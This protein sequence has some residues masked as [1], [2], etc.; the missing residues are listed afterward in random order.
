MR[1]IFFNTIIVLM[2]PFGFTSCSYLV[3]TAQPNPFKES[4]FLMGE[5]R[6][7][8]ED[9]E[10]LKNYKSLKT[11]PDYC[12]YR[13]WQ[14]IASL[15]CSEIIDKS[16]MKSKDT[17]LLKTSCDLNIAA[18]GRFYEKFKCKIY[19]SK[20][21]DPVEYDRWMRFS[22]TKKPKLSEEIIIF[23]R[24]GLTVTGLF[25]FLLFPLF[26]IITFTTKSD[27]ILLPKWFKFSLII[28]FLFLLPII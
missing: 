15:N 5:W 28:I 14:G 12:T 7:G 24:K 6:N 22:G 8:M 27:L 3:S 25:S 4:G 23:L 18:D 1:K 17:K 16:L 13:A 21:G 19:E 2:L 26:L 9:W 10:E 20:M 11:Q